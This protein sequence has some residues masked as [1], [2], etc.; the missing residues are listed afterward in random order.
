MDCYTLDYVYNEISTA[1]D[2]K[3][4]YKLMV[5]NRLEIALRLSMTK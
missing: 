2:F 4:Y 1:L 5:I 3:Y